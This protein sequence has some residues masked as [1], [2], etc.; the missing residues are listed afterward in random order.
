MRNLIF[1]VF[2]LILA[3]FG[4]AQS[5]VKT[6]KTLPNDAKN[7][8]E[9]TS[10]A[11]MEKIVGKTSS[12]AGAIDIDVHDLASA[13]KA[14]F[15][16]DLNTL[17]TGIGLRN[18]HMRENHL[19]TEKFPTATFTLARFVSSDKKGIGPGETANVVAEG[20]FKIH[21]VGKTYQIPVKLYYAVSDKATQTR[22]GGSMGALLNASAEFTVKLA[23]HEIKRPEL[24][25]MKLAPEQK[26]EV[27]FAMTD[28]LP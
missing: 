14:H 4:T 17:D 5:E 23:D 1:P 13:S 24:L 19:E 21:G 7:V 2:A 12:I 22:L 10:D 11:P 6:F 3:A 15:E 9:F 25:F 26:I 20:E 27:N 18:Q 16:V 8:V 28:V